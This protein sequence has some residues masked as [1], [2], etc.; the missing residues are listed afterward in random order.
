MRK[1]HSWIL[2]VSHQKKCDFPD[3]YESQAIR[4]WMGGFSEQAENEDF[5]LAT[6][7]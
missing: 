2:L 4:P 7:G 3:T 6:K 1:S 5:L